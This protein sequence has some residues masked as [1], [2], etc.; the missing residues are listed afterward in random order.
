MHQTSTTQSPTHVNQSHS[1]SVVEKTCLHP[2][3]QVALSSLDVQLEE[4]L[5]RYRRRR[6][7]YANYSPRPIAQRH[8]KAIDLKATTPD[9][10]AKL[11]AGTA[12]IEF[13]PTATVSP[14]ASIASE[15]SSE[16]SHQS[17][18]LKQ[19][20]QQYAAQVAN[21]ADLDA[22]LN[23]SPDDYL[24]SSEELLRTL[25]QEEAQ[26]QAEQGFMQ[27]LLTP[28]G[29]GS[30][31][32]LLMSSALFGFVIMNPNGISQLLADRHL[33]AKG[34]AGDGG[35][36]AT[37]SD[38]T[39]VPQPNLANQEFPELNLGHL[40]SVPVEPVAP[41]PTAPPAAPK[42]ARST[43]TANLGVS[44]ATGGNAALSGAE[45]PTQAELEPAP[46]AGD[47]P[48]PRKLA[49]SLPEPA[50]VSKPYLPPVSSYRPPTRSYRPSPTRSSNPL[51][52]RSS[53]PPPAK[54]YNPPPAKPIPALPAPSPLPP[55]DRTPPPPAAT[56]PAPGS[57][58]SSYKVVTPYTSDRTLEDYRG[59]VPDAYVKNYSDGAKVQF[60]AYQDE[61][62]AKSQVEE[63][64][65]QGI[66]AEVYKP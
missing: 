1:R 2:A 31:L 5:A 53:S 20:A 24:E 54:A 9:P 8:L 38:S 13:H 23:T 21:A 50:P 15:V 28:L 27:S 26:V 18:E 40:G 64:K 33:P 62:A 47:V 34:V 66:P 32:L 39:Q 29:I 4:E 45:A 35:I 37:G 48:S 55:S 11:P 22:S 60:G 12:G 51:P 65:K 16:P 44:G 61:A 43:Q 57:G 56:H 63:L 49:P 59:K 42:A 19:L 52:A 46:I 36:N 41:S 14:L 30:M 10:E 3:L 6:A 17:S 25:S 58:S 7:G